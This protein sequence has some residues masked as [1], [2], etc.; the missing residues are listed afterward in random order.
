MLPGIDAEKY[1]S[2]KL[3][4]EMNINRRE[5]KDSLINSTAGFRLLALKIRI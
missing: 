5:V 4:G 3:T 2:V 1:V